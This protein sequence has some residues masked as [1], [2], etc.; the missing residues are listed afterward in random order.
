MVDEAAPF[1]ECDDASGPVADEEQAHK[2]G[3][4][5]LVLVLLPPPML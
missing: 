3:W 1:L 4:A 5:R 2:R